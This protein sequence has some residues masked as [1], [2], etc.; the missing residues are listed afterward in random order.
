MRLYIGMLLLSQK[1]LN[2]REKFCVTDCLLKHTHFFDKTN[3]YPTLE[4]KVNMVDPDL[5]KKIL[6]I[7]T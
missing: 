6:F 2:L 1:G 4:G 7:K 5:E 3:K